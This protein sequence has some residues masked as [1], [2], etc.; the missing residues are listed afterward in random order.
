VKKSAFRFFYVN[1]FVYICI[2]IINKDITM[3]NVI[4]LT[5]I[6]T[7]DFIKGQNGQFRAIVKVRA[8]F[9]TTVEDLGIECNWSTGQQWKKAIDV[10]RGFKKGAL[11]TIE[12]KREGSNHWLTIFARSGNKIKLMD[13]E[14]M[15]DITVGDINQNWYS[16]NL[17][18]QNQYSAV[19]AKTW[20][21]KAYVGNI[22][23]GVDFS[24]S[25]QALNNLSILA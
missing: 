9:M 22:I 6:N 3:T 24:E 16:T 19:G 14:L 4:N 13:I 7:T 17:Y 8:G 1:L 10:F 18:S 11:Q 5:G 23:A 12:F 21:D 2:V 20:A 15:Q 25:I